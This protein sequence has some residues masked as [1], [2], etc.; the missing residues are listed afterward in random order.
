MM[1]FNMTTRIGFPAALTVCLALLAACTTARQPAPQQFIAFFNYNS[2]AI[3]P[4]VQP[5]IKEAA[6]AI[7]KA[8]PASVQ[9]AGYTGNERDP[10][11]ND[12]LAAQRFLNVENALV[13]EGVPRTLLTRVSLNDP[14]PLPATAVRRIEIRLVPAP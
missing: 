7:K 8:K 13:A 5:V 1:G 4:E 12:D 14:I 9:V 2:A 3:A 10:R 11:T 6:E